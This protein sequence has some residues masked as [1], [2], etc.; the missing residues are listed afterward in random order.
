[1]PQLN[2]Y[3][4]FDGE[5]AEAM[6]FYAGVL[7]AKLEALITYGQVPGGATPPAGDANRI[8]H[9]YLVHQPIGASR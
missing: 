9:T 2:A 5:C 8:M 3:L 7:G 6:Q 4:S 1:M